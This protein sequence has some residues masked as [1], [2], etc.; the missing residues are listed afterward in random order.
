VSIGGGKWGSRRGRQ[1]K[2]TAFI[3]RSEIHDK[4]DLA[5]AVAAKVETGGAFDKVQMYDKGI[6]SWGIKQWTLHRGSLQR[7]LGFIRGKLYESGQSSLWTKLFPGMDISGNRI[8]I[9]GKAY[10]VPQKDNDDADRALRRVFRGTEMSERFLKDVMDHWLVI[11]AQAG[12]H[13]YIRKL[14]FEYAVTSLRKN[15]EKHLGKILRA[16]REIK[17]S[18]VHN[19]RRVEDYIGS[20]SVAIAL[21]NGMETQNPRWT[22]RYLKRVVDRFAKRYNTYDTSRWHSN[23]PEEFAHELKREFEESGVTCWGRK[24]LQTKTACKGRTSRTT[25]MLR[26]YEGLSQDVAG[27]NYAL[28]ENA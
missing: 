8:E 9:R 18:E 12:R 26:A 3:S 6:L 19:Y 17:E 1:T 20:S 10:S 5:A 24:A 2:G 7:V 15:L 16:R 27:A 11:F 13:P 14:Q 23:W 21:F 4:Y 22:Y 28:S 25:K